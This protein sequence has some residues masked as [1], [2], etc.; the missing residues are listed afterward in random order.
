MATNKHIIDVQT[1]GAKKSEKQ[2]K[3]VSGALGGLAK[4][5]GI[6]AAA[7]FGTRALLGGV[8]KSIDLFANFSTPLIPNDPKTTQT[9]ELYTNSLIIKSLPIA[10]DTVSTSITNTIRVKATNPTI[11]FSFQSLLSL[12]I[13]NIFL[14][15]FSTFFFYIN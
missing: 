1:K 3:G 7:Y 9:K 2:I 14:C 8:Q 15:F 6:A 12:N 10:P 5:A 11:A 4:K 13:S